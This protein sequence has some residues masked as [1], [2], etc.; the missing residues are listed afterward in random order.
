VKF[1][2][3]DHAGKGLYLRQRLIAAGHEEAE[4]VDNIDL[5]LLDCDWPWAYPRPGLITSAV[6]HGAKVALYPHGGR[7]TVF[8]YD[9]I[10]E[11]D[12]RVSLRLEHG[13]GS[14]QITGHFTNNDLH[15]ETP[16][17]LYCP[18]RDFTPVEK[19]VKILF[20]PLHPNIE[21][22]VKGTNGHDPAP[23]LN[24]E[25]YRRLLKLR[26]MEIAVSLAGPAWRT[27]VWPHPRARFTENPMM[28]FHHSFEQI[29]SADVVVA[30]GTMAAAAVALGKPTV[31]FAQNIFVD[32]IDGKYV[33]AAHADLY[34]DLVRYPLDTQDDSLTN[35]INRA[36]ESERT[37]WRDLWVGHDGTETAISLL[38]NLVDTKTNNVIIGGATA[39]AMSR[40]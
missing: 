12:E 22:L 31:M 23:S 14:W 39:R 37:G 25:I 4:S 17:W 2:L 5:L 24:Q 18:T 26:N 16:G 8:V 19:P 30:A 15:Q 7:P 6:A 20:A 28:L 33:H 29:L 11:P 21:M 32:Y 1:T 36:C 27:G 35:L 34:R 40:S 3:Y 13:P 9:G 38:E 10:A